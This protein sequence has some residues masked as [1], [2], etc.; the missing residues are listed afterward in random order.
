MLQEGSPWLTNLPSN[1]IERVFDDKSLGESCY[2]ATGRST[3]GGSI[4]TL[5]QVLL[6][7]FDY[8]A[9]MLF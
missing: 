9:M 1:R 3:F 7:E 6:G 2:F 5:T 8:K 4:I